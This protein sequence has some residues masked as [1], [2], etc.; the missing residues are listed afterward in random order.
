MKSMYSSYLTTL[1]VA[2]LGLGAC[3]GNDALVVVTL[4]ATNPLANV[5]RLAVT[6]TVGTT[7]RSFDITPK[8]PIAIPPSYDFGIEVP[9]KLGGEVDITVVAYADTTELATQSGRI[10]IAKNKRANLTLTFGGAMPD[11][12]PVDLTGQAP[13]DLSASE[14]D[15]APGCD[16]NSCPPC[17]DCSAAGT[18]TKLVISADDTKG[19]VC[20]GANTCST[21]G[22]CKIRLGFACTPATEDTCVTGHCVDGVCCNVSAANC[23]ECQRCNLPGSEGTCGP[24]ADGSDPDNECGA[25]YNCRGG[26]CRSNC[27]CD[28]QPDLGTGPCNSVPDNASGMGTPSMYTSLDCK[29][30][31]YCSGSGYICQQ[32]KCSGSCGYNIECGNNV[33]SYPSLMCSC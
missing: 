30:G 10:A 20:E 15:L 24:V 22:A 7:S 33:C 18:C 1:L 32:K 16:E 29:A 11:L 19:Q 14:P 2:G 3:A 12:L 9:P 8:A 28:G 13:P 31:Y 5:T 17:A 6:A 25:A 27:H 21:T 23:G 26:V 4:D